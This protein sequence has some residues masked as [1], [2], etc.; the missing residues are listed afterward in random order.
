MAAKLE[1]AMPVN[2]RATLP[3]LIGGLPTT[4]PVWPFMMMVPVAFGLMLIEMVWQI[5]GHI[6]YFASRRPAEITR[7]EMF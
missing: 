6:R 7:Q 1:A 2:H 4:F 3:A 5:C